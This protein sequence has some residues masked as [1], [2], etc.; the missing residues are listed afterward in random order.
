M[1]RVTWIVMRASEAIMNG[2]ESMDCV[3]AIAPRMDGC[4]QYKIG[5]PTTCG[6]MIPSV[7]LAL[8][9]RSALS[10]ECLVRNGCRPNRDTRPLK[11]NPHRRQGFFDPQARAV[12]RGRIVATGTSAGNEEACGRDK[13]LIRVSGGT[14]P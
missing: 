6:R 2:K 14:A 5:K 8:S 10:L 4:E 1:L 12:S 3:V 7:R 9:S 11:E 13:Q